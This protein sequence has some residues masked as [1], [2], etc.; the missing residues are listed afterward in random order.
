MNLFTL[1]LD[2]LDKI[3]IKAMKSR[4]YC[5]VCKHDGGE[6]KCFADNVTK[7]PEIKMQINILQSGLWGLH[8]LKESDWLKNDNTKILPDR[9]N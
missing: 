7:C 1:V 2:E 4:K 8:E 3:H 9:R 5:R 6:M